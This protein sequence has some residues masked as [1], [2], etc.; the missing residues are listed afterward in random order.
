LDHGGGDHAERVTVKYLRAES[1]AH[2]VD[3][4]ADFGDDAKLLAGGQSLL[5]MMSAGFLRPEVVVDLDRLGELAHLTV[6][7]GEVK[8]GA[9]VRHC[10]LERAGGRVDAAFPLF[11]AAAPLIS[12]AP[13]RNRGTLVGSVV[14][15]DPGAEWPAVV[16]AAGGRVVL[17]SRAGERVVDAADFF[18][19]PLSSDV[20]PDEVAVEVRLPAAPPGS[21]AAVRELTYR[22]GDYAVVG[23]ACQAT[24]DDGGTV[25]DCRI[26]LFGVDATPVRAL[27]AEAALRSGGSVEDAARLA[28][29]AANPSSDATASAA[30]RKE[31]LLVYCRRALGAALARAA[32]AHGARGERR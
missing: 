4:M 30:Y 16:L 23:V 25:E 28:A 18:I 24:V 6:E 9:L 5:P 15:A 1:L 11:A 20:S 7:D 22:S 3:A 10:R 32:G 12:H 13:V 2:A 19:G 14:H 26:G 21:G 17:R 31:M 29:A 27:E 8:V